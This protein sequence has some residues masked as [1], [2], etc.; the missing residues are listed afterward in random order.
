MDPKT[1]T[2]MIALAFSDYS[3]EIC[4]FGLN[5]SRSLN[6]A[7]IVTT[8]INQRDVDAIGKIAAMGYDVD[9]R[10]YVEGIRKERQTL[11]EQY[12]QAASY[13]REKIKTIIKVGS[14]IKDLLKIAIAE[15]V[16]MIVMGV[17]GHT[18]LEHVF[19]GSVAE[20]VFR[21]SPITIVSYR[22]ATDAERLKKRLGF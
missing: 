7:V 22:C 19:V 17:K 13:P 9:S 6:A 20:K 1:T 8:I 21:K 2:I 14:P 18:D 10:D 5:L 4:L 15:Q 11:L 3:A 16:D 12:L